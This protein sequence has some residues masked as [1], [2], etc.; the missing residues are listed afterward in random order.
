MVRDARVFEEWFVGAYCLVRSAISTTVKDGFTPL[1]ACSGYKHNF[2]NLFL[3]VGRHYNSHECH[4]SQMRCYYKDK[5][6]P[7]ITSGSYCVNCTQAPAC[8]VGEDIRG[9][10]KCQSNGITWI[11]SNFHWSPRERGLSE[12]RSCRFFTLATTTL[13]IQ[14]HVYRIEKTNTA[15]M[16]LQTIGKAGKDIWEYAILVRLKL[17]H[18]CFSYSIHTW[19]MDLNPDL[20]CTSPKIKPY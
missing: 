15:L 18:G 6:A 3:C 11:C 14:R 8:I 1:Q 20:F 17:Q 10:I 2:S 4:N 16:Y 7:A 19:S 12:N 5:K 9:Q 13:L